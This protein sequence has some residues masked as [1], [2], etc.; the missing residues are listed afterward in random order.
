MDEIVL[1]SDTYIMAR[2][3]IAVILGY[4]TVSTF[5]EMFP[6]FYVFLY[7]PN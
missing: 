7:S 6:P 5:S 2:I 4:T 1:K 3:S